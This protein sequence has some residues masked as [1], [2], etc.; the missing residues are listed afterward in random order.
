M[1]KSKMKVTA[2]EQWRALR[3][4]GYMV[5]LPSRNVARLRPVSL[6]EMVKNGRIP[7]T[8]TPIAAEA[9]ST[10]GGGIPTETIIKLTNEVT[11][12]LH[13]VTVASFMEPRVVILKTPD[14]IPPDGAISIWDVSLEDQ[15][16]V[17]SLTGAPTR[18]LESFRKEQEADVALEPA[19]E[20]DGDKAE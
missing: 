3:E 10:I 6:A 14:E 11:D 8:L 7:D 1:A 12:F 18:A 9:I 15:A 19:V 4:D 5:E 13:L 17:L 16:F 2:T 20:D